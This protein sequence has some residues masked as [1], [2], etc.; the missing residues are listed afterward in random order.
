MDVVGVDPFPVA[1]GRP[2]ADD[3]VERPV[4]TWYHAPG[5]LKAGRG[6]SF[7]PRTSE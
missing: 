4:P 1:E 7:K 6:S 5:K 2:R 3:E